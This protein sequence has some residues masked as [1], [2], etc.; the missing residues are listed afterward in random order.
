MPL[1]LEHKVQG[2]SPSAGVLMKP[3]TKNSVSQMR[4]YLIKF[5]QVA[6]SIEDDSEWREVILSIQK[7]EERLRRMEKS[8]K[9]G[10]I[11]VVLFFLNEILE[12]V[13]EDEPP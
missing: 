2:I 6:N 8:L 10:N 9:L 13:V 7:Q 11:Y 1:A 5:L 12:S 3:K 4:G